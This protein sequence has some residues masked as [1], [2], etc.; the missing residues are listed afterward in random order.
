M[1]LRGWFILLTL[2]ISIILI[3]LIVQSFLPHLY[4]FYITESIVAIT[5]IYLLFFYRRV[6]NPIRAIGNGMELLKEQDFSSRLRHVRQKD[7]DRIVDVFNRMIT[8]LKDERLHVRETNQFLDLLIN[9]SPMGVV[10][11]DYDAR[12]TSLNPA[13]EKFLEHSSNDIKGKGISDIHSSLA[14]Q[15][16]TLDKD[17]TETFQL[18]DSHIYRCSRLS[19]IDHGYAHPFILI[20]SLTDEVMKAEKKAYENVIRMIAHEV[21]NTIAGVTSTLDSVTQALEDISDTDDLREVMS[22]C[23]ERSYS[24]SKFITKFADVVKIPEPQLQECNICTTVDSCVQIME[25]MLDERHIQLHWNNP[26]NPVYIQADTP[27]LEQVIVNIIK[28]SAE[29]I[30]N[31]GDIT[32]TVMPSPTMLEITD[33][34]AGIDKET[35]KKLFSPF[36]STKP[37][38]Q[39]VGL[40]FI[41]EVLTKHGF[42]FSLKT[43]Q[44][45]LTRFRIF[46]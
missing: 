40:I 32:L 30:G 17:T 33:N 26:D 46:F 23:I 44:D 7:A 19:F 5:I 2:L 3:L 22:A 28:N 39:G 45:G 37:N 18:N 15:L 35:E 9:A 43:Y 16:V 36:F 11:M 34:G 12:I 25:S 31:Q 21:N 1:R 38:G 6:I 42:R 29:S 14:D 20:E 27:L 13:A 8:Q 4:L 24:M 10:I 41:R